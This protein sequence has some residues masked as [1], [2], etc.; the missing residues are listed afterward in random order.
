MSRYVVVVVM[1]LLGHLQQ[2]WWFNFTHGVLSARLLHHH[3]VVVN[4]LYAPGG[5]QVWG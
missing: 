1:V 5:V 3:L 2:S 4:L